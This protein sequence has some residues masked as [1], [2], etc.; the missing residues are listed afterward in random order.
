MNNDASD[1]QRFL[2]VLWCAERISTNRATSINKSELN[3]RIEGIKKLFV[4]GSLE[5]GSRIIRPASKILVPVMAC[6]NSS[7]FSI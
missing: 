2:K 7:L 6:V 1:L 3:H 5:I 4:A